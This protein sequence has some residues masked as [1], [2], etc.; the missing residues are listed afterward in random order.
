[1]TEKEDMINLFGRTKIYTDELSITPANVV[2]VLRESFILHS[3][4]SQEIETLYQFY[5]G[6]QPILY[7]EK[8]IRPEINNRIVENRAN[9]IVAFKTGFLCGEPLQCVSRG[10]TP[11]ISDAI[12]ELNDMLV[13]CNKSTRDKEL[14]EWAYICGQAYRIVVPNKKEI[15][16][17]IVPRLLNKPVAFSE[18]EAPFNIYTLD[19]RFTFSVYSSSLGE[20]CVM[21]VKFIN[22]KDGV[23]VFSIYTDTTYYEVTDWVVTKVEQNM[24]G[25]IPIVEYVLNNARLGAFEIVIPILNAINEVQ[26]DRLN[27]IEQFV[28]SLI[29]LY[30]AEVDDKDVKNIRDAGLITLKS[31]GENKGDIKEISSEL[32]QTQTQ[33]LVD[34]MYQT[35]LNI[36]GMPNRNGGLSTSDTGSAVVMRDGWQAAEARAK[37][38]E[39]M[40]KTS[41]NDFLKVVLRIMRDTVGTPLRLADIEVKFTRR[42][43]ENILSKSQ[44]LTTMLSNEKIAPILA[45]THCGLFSDPEDAAQMSLEHYEAVKTGAKIGEDDGNEPDGIQM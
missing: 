9:E 22:R 3:K 32:N 44:V 28:Q 38:D 19:P 10:K 34:Y 25:A 15:N 31:F 35:V 43:F 20:P 41:E 24:V 27:A 16:E 40:F 12:T 18:D 5:K 6:N 4:N 11:D 37:E 1:M 17:K 33:T 14:V 39:L 29:V 45:F 7:R 23:T 2:G 13:M 30:N 8:K 42:N 36:A 21:G 26:S